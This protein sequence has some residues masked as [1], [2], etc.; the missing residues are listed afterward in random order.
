MSETK[1]AGG[2]DS[3]RERHFQDRAARLIALREQC[4]AALRSPDLSPVERKQ[5]EMALH[6]VER[7]EKMEPIERRL[8]EPNLTAKEREDLMY[9]YHPPE[10]RSEELSAEGQ[11]RTNL[12]NLLG[13]KKWAQHEDLL[14]R[15]T[16]TLLAFENEDKFHALMAMK[17]QSRSE[18]GKSWK[19]AVIWLLYQWNWLSAMSAEDAAALTGLLDLQCPDP[20]FQR[21]PSDDECDRIQ[22]VLWHLLPKIDGNQRAWELAAEEDFIRE[23]KIKGSPSTAV[24]ADLGLSES[25]IRQRIRRDKQRGK[26]PS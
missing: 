25:A 20:L 12:K 8:M 4:E 9:L 14:R 7:E 18:P 6:S 13:T 19:V 22:Q 24:G 11:C 16:V 2:D 5:C 17:H 15:L 21:K 26:S 10:S 3:W 1:P 23:E